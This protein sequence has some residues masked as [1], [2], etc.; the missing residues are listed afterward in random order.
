MKRK[1]INVF[2]FAVLI[3]LT[4][5]SLVLGN[6]EKYFYYANGEK[7]FLKVSSDYIG[8]SFKKQRSKEEIKQWFEKKGVKFKEDTFI[9]GIIVLE[10]TTYPSIDA[11]EKDLRKDISIKLVHPVL[12]AKNEQLLLTEEFLVKFK[13]SISD[14][15]IENINN[16]HNIKIIKRPSYDRPYHTLA[17]ID[18]DPLKSLEM[19]NLYYENGLVEWASPNFLTKI[20]L[21]G[22]PNDTYFS[23]QWYLNKINYYM[24]LGT[25]A[26][27]LLNPCSG[28]AA[29]VFRTTTG[30]DLQDRMFGSFGLSLPTILYES[31]KQYKF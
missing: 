15:H 26:W 14:S 23:N 6:A 5:T 2:Y 16:S 11:L 31:I 21:H 25:K 7:I 29:D 27:N 20:T 4:N 28:F 3:A 18:S 19:A 17:S 1:F 13:S 30:I 8:V 22:V 12:F 9:N 24:S 10:N